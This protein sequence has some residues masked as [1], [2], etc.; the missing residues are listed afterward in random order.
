[1]KS[2]NEKKVTALNAAVTA[3]RRLLHGD[4][5]NQFSNGCQQV[6]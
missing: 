3:R 5:V 1:L 6:K 2:K 4:A